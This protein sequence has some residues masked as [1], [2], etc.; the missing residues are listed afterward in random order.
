MIQFTEQ[1]PKNYQKIAE[2]E[3]KADADRNIA[4]LLLKIPNGKYVVE[5]LN[6]ALLVA[7]RNNPELVKSYRI[8]DQMFYSVGKLENDNFGSSKAKFVIF[9]KVK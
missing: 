4:E 1:Q 5:T 6:H 7:I 3:F 8:D 9:A 2:G